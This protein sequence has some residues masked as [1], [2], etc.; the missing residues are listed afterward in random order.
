M[1][2]IFRLLALFALAV[3]VV[4][5][6]VDAT[7][8]IAA[9][10]WIFTPL[11]ESWRENFPETLVAIQHFLKAHHVPFLWDPAITSIL[12]LPGWLVFALIA[13]LFHAAGRRRHRPGDLLA[14]AR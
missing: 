7:R 9:G 4:M 14:A 10:A 6:V 12:L 13:F 2:F 5:A 3:A 11:G 1:R 8:T